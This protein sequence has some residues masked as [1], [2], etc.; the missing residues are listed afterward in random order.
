MP[1]LVGTT[2]AANYLKVV[3]SPGAAYAGL[4]SGDFAPLL[5]FATPNLRLF[6][7]IITGEDLTATPAASDSSYSKVVR[8]LQVT[9]ELFAVFPPSVSAG[10]STMLFM[11]PDFNSNVG[12]PTTA[13]ANRRECSSRHGAPRIAARHVARPRGLRPWWVR[14]WLRGRAPV[15]A[16][17]RVAM[18]L[19][20]HLPQRR[21][22]PRREP[23]ARSVAAAETGCGR[24]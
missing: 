23:A 4:E 19:R 7:V 12:A 10:D 22:N 20:P 11:A 6:K 9:C 16:W 21:S 1:S 3:Q 14:P 17:P 2:V 8:A 18:A 24:T 13:S 5:T 15:A